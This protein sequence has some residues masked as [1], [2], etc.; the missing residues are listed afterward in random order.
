M[1]QGNVYNNLRPLVFQST[2]DVTQSPITNS[3]ITTRFPVVQSVQ[4]SRL[5]LANLEV[6][7]SWFN[8]TAAY[9]NTTFSYKWPNGAGFQTF[10][11]TLPDGNYGIDDISNFLQFQMQAN[12]TYLIDSAGNNQYFI[13]FQTNPIYLRTTLTYLTVPTSLPTGWLY[14][15][16]TTTPPAGYTLPTVATSPQLVI[17]T[18]GSSQS[19]MSSVLGFAPGSYPVVTTSSGSV[20]GQY[21]PEIDVVQSVNVQ[22]SMVNQGLVS[23]SPNVIYS[24]SAGNTTFGGLIS[25]TPPQFIWFPVN[26][27][28]YASF[29]I[30][31]TDQNNNALPLADPVWGGTVLLQQNL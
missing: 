3:T 31:L 7:F 11:V 30:S 1:S 20:N 19:S 12:G 22:C 16:G 23:Q 13:S 9:G 18:K 2:G 4:A 6:F 10:T 27:G 8:I 14:S 24:F 28:N 5:A 17:P 25:V 15:T 21:V 26:D 29:A